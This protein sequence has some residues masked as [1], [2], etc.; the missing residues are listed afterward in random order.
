MP[1][2]DRGHESRRTTMATFAVMGATGNIGGRIAEQLLAGGHTVRALGRSVE[3]LAGLKAKG[4]EVLTGD[5]SDAAFLTRAFTGADGVFTMQPPNP[6]AP[7]FRA[8]MDRFGTAIAEAVAKSGVRHVV[9]LSSVGAERASGTGP[10]AGLHAQEERLKAIT[11]ANVLILRPGYFFENFLHILPLVRHQGING[12]GVAGKTSIP[13]IATRDIAAFAA[14]ALATRDWT[15][16]KVQELLGPRDL[17]FDEATRI[18]GAA[19]GKP[20][21]AYVQFP[22]ADYSAALQQNGLS[23]SVA[24]LYAEMEKAFD[25]GLVVSVEGRNTSNTT[26]TTLESFAGE[27]LAPAYNS[28][29]RAA[30]A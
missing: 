19:I 9:A 30:G 21:L 17:T 16:A 27:V 13:M 22:Y 4:A 7:D 29:A 3:K 20:D 11:G 26:P 18:L 1:D 12:G 25:D 15:G 24:D 14:G 6:V 28:Q 23:K 2:L 10:I 8:E 5:A